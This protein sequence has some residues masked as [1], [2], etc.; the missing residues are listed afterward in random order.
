MSKGVGLAIVFFILGFSLNV[1]L[2]AEDRFA[3]TDAVAEST[4]RIPFGSIKVYPD[5]VRIEYPGL[6]YA[7]VNSD[8]MAP[9]MT[10]DSVVFEKVPDSPDEIHIGDAISFFNPVENKVILHA[11]VDIV[12]I[13]GKIFYETKGIANPEADDALVPYENVKGI[14]VGAFR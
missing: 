11:V 7:K 5:E 13:D 4:Q 12:E 10:H 3:T 14:V 6:K 9:W 2:Q 1:P 8:S